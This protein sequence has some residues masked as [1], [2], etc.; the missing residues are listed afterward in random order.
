MNTLE[1][2][3]HGVFDLAT[4]GVEALKAMTAIRE[5]ESRLPG[6]SKEGLI[7]GSTH[8]SVGMEAIAVGVSRSLRAADSI[9]SNHRGHAHCLAKGADPGRT[10]AEI[11]GRRDG[12]CGG[13]GGSMHIGVKE[14]GILGTNGIVGAGIGLATGAA[15]AAQQQE[16]GAVAVAYFG[17]GASNQGVLAESFNL[18]AIWK[19]PVIFVCENN[20]FAQSAT[21]E[22]MVAQ[23]EIRRRGEAYG[24]PSFD[25]D[26]MDVEAVANAASE[27][28]V[29]ARSGEGPTFLVADTYRYLGHMADD[30]EIY[31]TREQV[32][33]WKGRDP[34]AKLAARLLE[35]AVLTQQDIDAIAQEAI[36]EVDAAEAFAK[37]SPFPE[38]AEAF[39]QVSEDNR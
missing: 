17:D 2:I 33:A 16:S 38:T 30:T 37:A 5:F 19:L 14:L 22:E 4:D 36:A 32:E 20:H 25:V 18:A 27:A 10:L 7:R 12:Y 39:T 21:L 35:R 13:K 31:R 6:Y 34:I 3:E 26:G 8:P 9:A 1:A 23:P 29:R 28:A 11:L 24:V 15:L